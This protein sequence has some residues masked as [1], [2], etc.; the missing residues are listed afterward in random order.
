MYSFLPGIRQ[1]SRRLFMPQQVIKNRHS[2][3]PAHF[4]TNSDAIP[5]LN[6]LLTASKRHDQNR[7][8]V[9]PPITALS[10][11]VDLHN[12]ISN[13]DLD[14]AR[15]RDRSSNQYIP[16]SDVEGNPIG[17]IQKEAAHY[18]GVLHLAFSIFVFRMNNG[19]PELLIQQ[20]NSEKYHSGGLW[21]NTC[22]SHPI[23]NPK[24]GELYPIKSSAELRLEEETGLKNL[25]LS[26]SG[27]FSYRAEIKDLLEHEFDHV[28]VGLFEADQHEITVDPNEIQATKWVSFDQLSESL[29]SKPQDFVA[30]LH[31]ALT[32]ALTGLPHL[33]NQNNDLAL[34][35]RAID[36]TRPA[37]HPAET[38]V[39]APDLKEKIDQN[40]AYFKGLAEEIAQ[41]YKSQSRTAPFIVGVSGIS[42]S[43]KT[44]LATQLAKVLTNDHQLK[45]NILHM[46][47]F[48]RQD[49]QKNPEWGPVHL[50]WAE[51]ADTLKKIRSRETLISKPTFNQ[52]TREYG[53]EV[54]NSADMKVVIVEGL[55]ALSNRE[56]ISDLMDLK[57]FIDVTKEEAYQSRLRRESRKPAE[58]QVTGEKM[59]RQTLFLEKDAAQFIL[60]ARNSADIIVGHPLHPPSKVDLVSPI[61]NQILVGKK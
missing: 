25:K 44:L 15:N 56:G 14:L 33:L 12:R 53:A 50:D 31:P 3:F 6:R 54:I 32:Q 30:W 24:T 26:H 52:L 17:K 59:E 37:I 60:P 23:F 28:Y 61:V 47:D 22:C 43:A 18:D 21:A 10:K 41:H 27:Q 57:I 29:H 5:G 58:K 13:E 7:V 45:A 39:E 19:V 46:D 4:S 9:F 38:I 1:V 42:G 8:L 55:Y 48:I 16:M 11:N 34:A 49:M 20:R 51:M 40:G 36:C 2:G 35:D